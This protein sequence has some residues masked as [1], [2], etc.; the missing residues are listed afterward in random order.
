MVQRFIK[1]LSELAIKKILKPEYGQATLFV[2][3]FIN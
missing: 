2:V 3:N 1:C